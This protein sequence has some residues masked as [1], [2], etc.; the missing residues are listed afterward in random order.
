MAMKSIGE[1]LVK[2][3]QHEKESALKVAV[4]EKV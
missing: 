1:G 2:R 4:R 3:Q